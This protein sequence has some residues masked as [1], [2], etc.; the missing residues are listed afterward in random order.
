[1]HITRIIRWPC[2][3]LAILLMFTGCRSIRPTLKPVGQT[4]P[5]RKDDSD[6]VGDETRKK[7]PPRV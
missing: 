5:I 4:E 7:S 2:M 3:S 1:M 6:T